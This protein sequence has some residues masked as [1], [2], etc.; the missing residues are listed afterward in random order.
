MKRL[1]QLIQVL[2][3]VLAGGG[4]LHAVDLKEGFLGITWGSPVSRLTG[5]KKISQKGE[6]SYYK[7]PQSIYSVFG[8]D[9]ADVVLG[10][11]RDQFFAAYIAIESIDTYNRV[12]N[13]LIQE[14]GPPR[15]I[16]NTRYQQTILRWTQENTRIKLK[17]Y[18]KEGR[19]KLAFY[20]EPL[21]SKLNQAQREEIEPFAA[22][23]P[24]TND[25]NQK[26][27]IKE[28]K[29]RQAIDVMGF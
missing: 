28:R 15:T 29:L 24:F 10:F 13:Q 14:F 2:V 12:K 7:N 11:Y 26:E 27:A 17:L 3:L 25:K 16:L 8:V 22:E 6:V 18:E 23:A 9:A 20:Y 21:A 19:M 4:L 5:Y 1:K